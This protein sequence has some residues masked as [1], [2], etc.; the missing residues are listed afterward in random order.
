MAPLPWIERAFPAF[1]GLL[2]EL[3][4]RRSET[5]GAAD[6][7]LRAEADPYGSTVRITKA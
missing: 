4:E 2:R 3:G 1:Y 7:G 5:P 6:P